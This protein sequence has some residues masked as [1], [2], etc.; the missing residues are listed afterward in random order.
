MDCALRSLVSDSEAHLWFLFFSDSTSLLLMRKES[1]SF[2]WTSDS[3]CVVKGL[4]GKKPAGQYADFLGHTTPT[5]WHSIPRCMHMRARI[6]AGCTW[7]YTGLKG[8]KRNGE[9]VETVVPGSLFPRSHFADPDWSAMFYSQPLSRLHVNALKGIRSCQ[10]P[11]TPCRKVHLERKSQMPTG[12]RIK[13]K[14]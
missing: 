9:Q 13:T 11:F 5:V 4:V 8:W 12:S 2:P 7:L 10:W 1:G 6:P 3:R 14:S